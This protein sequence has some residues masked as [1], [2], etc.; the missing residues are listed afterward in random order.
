MYHIEGPDLSTPMGDM[1]TEIF[2]YFDMSGLNVFYVEDGYL[3]Q[4]PYVF[5]D[6][7]HMEAV[8]KATFKG[9]LTFDLSPIDGHP[10]LTDEQRSQWR[11]DDSERQIK[12]GQRLVLAFDDVVNTFM[13]SQEDA[14]KQAFAWLEEEYDPEYANTLRG[15]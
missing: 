13:G 1:V 11:I 15:N 3:V 10:I 12:A 14:K 5:A 8:A 9:L 7:G 6:A 2:V 4:E